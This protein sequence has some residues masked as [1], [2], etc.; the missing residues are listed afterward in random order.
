MPPK[1]KIQKEDIAAAGVELVRA[2][3]EEA[4]NARAVA[5]KLGC[6]TQPIFSNY[7]TMEALRQDV[8][9]RAQVI[10]DEYIA[11]A[12]ARRTYPPYKASGLAYIGFAREERQLFRLLFMRDRAGERIEEDRSSIRGVLDALREKTGLSGDEAYRFHMEMWIWVHGVAVMAAT[13]Y[14]DWPMETVSGMMTDIFEGLRRQ[15]AKKE[16]N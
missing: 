3:G 6:S 12:M 5:K 16:E 9:A 1:P 7:P 10:Y 4:L 2:G 13:D 11:A 15:Y 8:I 14:L